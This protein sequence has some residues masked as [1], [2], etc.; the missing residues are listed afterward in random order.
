MPAWSPAGN[1]AEWYWHALAEGPKNAVYQF[2]HRTYGHDFAYADFAPMFKAELFDPTQWAAL[3]DKAG[4]K[5]VVVTSKHH[6]GYA[7]WD[8]PQ[9]W[10]WN[11]VDTGPHRY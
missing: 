10:N 6:E 2:H 7:M 11:S 4:A 1:Y 8:S 5:Y 3:F 9:S